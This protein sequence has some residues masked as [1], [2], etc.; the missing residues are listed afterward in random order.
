M[1]SDAASMEDY[2][3]LY[4]EIMAQMGG[5]G[6]EGD[7][8]GEGEG[9][10]QGEGDGD[11]DGLGGQGVGRGSKAPED[12]AAKTAFQ[13]EKTKTALK[14]GKI[15]LS[16]KTKDAPNADIKDMQAEY[17]EIITDIKQATE[18]A[19]ER[20]EAPPGYHNGIK[21]YFDTLERLEENQAK[22]AVAPQ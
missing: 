13:T 17:R 8:E 11:G 22:P 3:A 9:E 5:E 19:I 1:F 15:L 6:M 10:G 16:M 14:K 4:E 7:G 18:E 2:E 20:E 12:D 21:K